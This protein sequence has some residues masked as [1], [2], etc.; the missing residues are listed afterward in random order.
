MLKYTLLLLIVFLI[1]LA[2]FAPAS[3]LDRAL[4]NAQG[5]DLVNPRGTVWSGQAGIVVA[6]AQRGVASWSVRPLSVLT[7]NPTA[8][9]RIEDVSLNLEGWASTVGEHHSLDVQGLI[10]AEVINEW[11]RKYY[12]YLEGEF[13]VQPTQLSVSGTQVTKLE[14][15]IDWTGGVV[16][17]RLSGVLHETN[18]P[19][20][21]AYLDQDTQAN[22][23][24]T[25]YAQGNSTPLLFA[26]LSE[27][28]FAKVSMTKLFTKL[29]NNPWPGSDPDSTIVLEVEEK[30]I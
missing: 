12:I 19:P 11:L 2:A 4:Q 27:D 14:G 1:C 28:G 30:I 10:G 23:I 22:P 26:T 16:R 18:L 24:A 13:S 7:F 29:L 25:V 8:D 21:T 6:G 5:V 3:L 9:W 17:Y 20:L 15:Q